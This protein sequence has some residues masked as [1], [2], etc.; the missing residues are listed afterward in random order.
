MPVPSQPM[1][2]QPDYP[3][4]FKKWQAIVEGPFA[5]SKYTKLASCREFKDLR[6]EGD[7]GFEQKDPR[8]SQS[9]AE[10]SNPLADLNYDF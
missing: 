4:E 2:P 1:P 7:A 6:D 5:E 3:E 9:G 10:L 8:A